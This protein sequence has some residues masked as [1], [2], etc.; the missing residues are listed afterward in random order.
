[1]TPATKRRL[2]LAIVPALFGVLA[3]LCIYVFPLT[4]ERIDE[5]KTERRLGFREWKACN[6]D[7][8]YLGSYYYD[9]DNR[10]HAIEGYD[11]AAY[12]NF[13]E[14]FIRRGANKDRPWAAWLSWGPPHDPY[15]DVPE[16]WLRLYA[17]RSLALRPNVPERI[18]DRLDLGRH[19]DRAT[20]ERNLVDSPDHAARRADLH[21]AT[22][23]HAARRDA[24]FP[25]RT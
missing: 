1:L 8:A 23:A 7:H 10:R 16:E 22:A 2:L 20:V 25:G 14:D 18:V 11:A 3:F 17:G 15:F 9:E 19:W 13:A 5:A 21:A 6:C 12:A 24:L 4:R